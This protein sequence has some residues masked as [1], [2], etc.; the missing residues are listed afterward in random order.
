MENSFYG[1]S[2]T[3]CD[4]RN[5]SPRHVKT[6]EGERLAKD[7]GANGFIENSSKQLR[8]IDATFQMAILAAISN[9]RFIKKKRKNDCWLL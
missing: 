4:L 7:I 8:N 6:E 2:G 3:K 1:L 9:T 5:H